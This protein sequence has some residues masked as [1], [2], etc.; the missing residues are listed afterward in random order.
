V[1][2]SI[3]MVVVRRARRGRILAML[4]LACLLHPT[5]AAAGRGITSRSDVQRSLN[6]MMNPDAAA[7]GQLR[8]KLSAYVKRM[9]GGRRQLAAAAGTPH[10]SDVPARISSLG[11]GLAYHLA[12]PPADSESGVRTPVHV[13]CTSQGR[14]VHG[15]CRAGAGLLA[16][17]M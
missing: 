2:E 7:D 11:R 17:S 13:L 8:R 14:A 10:A 3:V 5:V 12:P 4:L 15:A 16:S 9:N 6:T 1:F